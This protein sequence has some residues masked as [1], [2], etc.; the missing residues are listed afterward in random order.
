[1]PYLQRYMWKS[2]EPSNV[3]KDGDIGDNFDQSIR[4]RTNRFDILSFAISLRTL[5][6]MLYL[7]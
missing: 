2:K 3:R 1:M 6:I 7:L 4:K 5:I